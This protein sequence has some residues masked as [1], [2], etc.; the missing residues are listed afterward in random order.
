[1]PAV[2]ILVLRVLKGADNACRVTA[3][4]ETKVGY[5]LKMWRRAAEVTILYSTLRCESEILPRFRQIYFWLSL[6]VSWGKMHSLIYP[7]LAWDMVKA[8]SACYLREYK[9]WCVLVWPPSILP[10]GWGIEQW[11]ISHPNPPP[12][13]NQ[14]GAVL[15]NAVFGFCDQWLMPHICF[16]LHMTEPENVS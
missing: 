6:H 8:F 12:M 11:T 10:K 2:L 3:S 5:R 9:I 14:P 7:L 1:M 15:E 4:C 16:V 13:C